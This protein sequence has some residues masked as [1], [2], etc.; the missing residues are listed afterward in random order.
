[1]LSRRTV[2]ASAAALSVAPAAQ[3]ADRYAAALG[4]AWGGPLDPLAAHRLA[5]REVERLQSRLVVRLQLQG[6]GPGSSSE[7]LHKAFAAERFLYSDDDAGRNRAVADMNAA[8][9]TLRPRLASAFSGGIPSA[10]VRRMSQE[11]E[12]K[13]RGGYREPGAYYVDLKAIRDRPAW[14]L[15]SVAFHE[16][17]PGH[18]LQAAHLAASP[19]AERQRHAGVFSEAWA[20]YAEQL[21]DDLGA[22]ETDPMGLIGY[23]HWRLFRM[24][25]VVV[26][27]GQ[28]ALGWSLDEAVARLTAMQ[29]RSIAF[30]AIEADAARMRREPG[31]FAAQGLGALEIARLRPRRREDWPAFHAAILA[32]GPWP[33]AMLDAKVRKGFR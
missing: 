23:L 13:G 8:L 10:E 29:G 20:T 3:S 9:A 24:A 16:T 33:C 26:D 27:T 17:V 4:Q 31:V 12:A 1:M 11:D 21:A 2:I 14:T 19:P 15:P 28:G 32:D 7:R 6:F 5:L 18:A 25:R 22:Y 30:V